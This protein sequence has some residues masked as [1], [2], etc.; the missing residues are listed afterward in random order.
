MTRRGIAIASIVGAALA[1]AACGAGSESAGTNPPND[2]AVTF[3]TVPESEESS[4]ASEAA[5]VAPAE[6]IATTLPELAPSAHADLPTGT[7]EE[8]STTPATTIASGPLP[9]PVVALVDAGQ[10]DTPVELFS[11]IGDPRNFVV[12]QNGRI[13]AVDDLSSVVVLDITNLTAA[14]GERGL[15]G[16]AFHPAQDFAYVHYNDANGTTVLDE[17]AIDPVTAVFDPNSRRE[18]LTVQ[19]PFGNHNG[20][21]LAFGPDGLLYL[22]LG[23]G[24][25]ANDPER[26]SLALASRLGKILRIDPLESGNEPF[27]TPADNPFVDVE[28][29]DP[30]IW[31]LGL[32]NP[33]KFSFDAPT[34][35]LWIADVGQG[36]LEEINFA[37]AID[38]QGAGRGLSFG[39]SAFEGTARFNDDQDPDGHT[40]PIVEYNHDEGNCSVSGGVVY[41]GDAI[42]DLQG[43]FVYG[44]FCSGQIWGYDT[45]SQPGAP[46]IVELAQQPNLAAIAIGGEGDLFAVSNIGTVS[47]FVPA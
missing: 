22:G 35:D 45:T 43:W 41:R 32:R 9:I 23:D 3:A 44:D 20:G 27:T 5:D 10:F 34:G 26:N 46:I 15:L 1:V 6:S 11:R 16:A 31:A 13:V 30:T 28:G 18:V 12:E 38:G 37:P 4:T 29:A 42:A 14:D 24:G 7:P 19:Q 39:W 21:E 47:R 40:P 33:W 36:D 17:Y 8:L 2:P 25:A